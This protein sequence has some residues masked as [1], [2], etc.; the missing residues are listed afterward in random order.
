VPPLVELTLGYEFYSNEGNDP[1]EIDPAFGER[2]REEFLR[3]I[4]RLAVEMA[5]SLRAMMAA[6]RAG[7][8]A[9]PASKATV[10]LAAC[11][12]DMHATWEQLAT[13]LRM[14]GYEV[15]PTQE[16]PL[17]EEALIPEVNAQLERCAVSI[18]LVGRSAGPIPDGPSGRSLVAV[19]NELAAAR[20]RQ[21]PLQRIIWLPDGIVGERPEHQLFIEAILKDANLQYGA[22]LL[23]GDVEA[24]KVAIHLALSRIQTAAA[25]AA[26]AAAGKPVVHLLMTEG[27]RVAAV[28]LIKALR[29]QGLEVT[30]PVFVGDARALRE[31][32][33]QLVG[34]CRLVAV[35]YGV[36]DEVWKFH[37]LG[38]LNKQ[39]ASGA[40]RP[41]WICLAPP[42]TPDK[43]ML[44]ALEEPNVINLLDG[45]SD[46]ALGPLL[47]A[48]RGD[49]VAP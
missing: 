48:L 28:P 43:E 26:A 20:C 32:N 22:D 42:A 27:D 4:S 30:V 16:L 13:D 19:Q 47:S 37:Q 14:H 38:D 29:A 2:S 33:A 21:A 12:R 41:V 8:A 18:H 15:V 7:D 1:E 40:A 44:R 6:K 23:R 45:V 17:A 46:A 35:F 5:Q 36:G 31:A 3:R 11:G 10:F 25:P 39:A 34:A 24:V 49:K 9:A